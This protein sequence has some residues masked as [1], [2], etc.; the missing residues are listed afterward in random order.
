MKLTEEEKKEI[1]SKYNDGTS[2]EVL[3][4]LRRTYPVSEFKLSFQ[5]EP[6]KIIMIGGKSVILKGN[7]KYLV[8]KLNSM[9][10]DNFPQIDKKEIRRTIKKFLDAYL[11]D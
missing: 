8:N 3:N 1:L 10:E 11:I 7:K 4:H 5:E 2:N 9:V 6:T